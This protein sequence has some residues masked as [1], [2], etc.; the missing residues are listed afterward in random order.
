[1][2]CSHI[3]ATVEQIISYQIFNSCYL[4]KINA[5]LSISAHLHIGNYGNQIRHI[6]QSDMGEGHAFFYLKLY[7]KIMGDTLFCVMNIF[8]S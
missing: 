2:L 8:S 1:M 3:S 7:K 5:N 6:Y 4:W